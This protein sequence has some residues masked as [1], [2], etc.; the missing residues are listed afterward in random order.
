MFA[1]CE[2]P[3][4][5]CEQSFLLTLPLFSPN[6]GSFPGSLLESFQETLPYKAYGVTPND[7]STDRFIH[8][9]TKKAASINETAFSMFYPVN[10]PAR[11]DFNYQFGFC[12]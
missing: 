10:I 7:N 5:A 3:F 1:A 2:Y 6:S 8:I 12:G 11:I 9:I 4:A